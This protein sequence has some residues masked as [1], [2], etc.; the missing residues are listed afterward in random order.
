M[1]SD[2]TLTKRV[3]DELRWDRSVDQSHIGVS[4]AHGAVILSGHVPNYPEKIAACEAAKRVKGVLAVADEIEVDLPAEWRRDDASIAERIAHVLGW[5]VNVPQ[6]QVKASVR[7]GYVTLSG[8]VDWQYQRAQVL[9]QIRHVA[10]L[11]GLTSEIRIKPRATAVSVQNQIEEA[12][13]RHSQEEAKT[14]CVTVSGDAV[15]LSGHIAAPYQRDLVKEAAWS[16]PG[17]RH[18]ID[19]MELRQA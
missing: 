9:Q 15:T 4:S 16:A 2:S 14:V 5:G 1:V 10:G 17:V 11:R 12:L 18:V 8:E 3:L 6:D 19:N 7:N 13:Y